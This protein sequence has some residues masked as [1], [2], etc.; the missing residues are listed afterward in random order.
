MAACETQPPKYIH[1]RSSNGYIQLNL[2]ISS[3]RGDR[4]TVR[5][6]KSSTCWKITEKKN[7][8]MQR[9]LLLL[10]FLLTHTIYKQV[11]YFEVICY[12]LFSFLSVSISF[13][14]KRTRFCISEPYLLAYGESF[15]RF[16][17]A[18]FVSLFEGC[19][20]GLSLITISSSSSITISITICYCGIEVESVVRFLLHCPLCSN[21]RCTLL[22][23]LSRIDHKLL[24]CT[25]TI[26]TQTFLFGNSSYTTND[27]TK[28]INLTIDSVVSTKKFDGPLL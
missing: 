10:T 2:G 23:S 20:G 3:S 1:F 13:Y 24:D 22:N 8:F 9:K 4:K 5:D 15:C 16:S 17:R 18:F 7:K 26:L 19:T 14:N 25:D 12:W 27:S 28:I 11:P 6:I 21:E